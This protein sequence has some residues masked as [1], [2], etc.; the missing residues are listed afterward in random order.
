MHRRAASCFVRA[1]VP[2]ALVVIGGLGMAMPP[3]ANGA[4]GVCGSKAG[5]PSVAYRHVVVIMDENKSFS[6]IIGPRGSAARRRAPFLNHLSKRCGLAANY[7]GITHPSHPNYMAITGGIPAAGSSEGPNVFRQVRRS[8]ETW[9]SY[10]FSMRRPC[11]HAAQYPYKPGHNPGIAWL[12]IAEDCRR[13]D[14]NGR[15]LAADIAHRS[16]PDYAFITPDQCHNM[17]ASCN[18]RR[19]AVRAGDDWLRK[20]VTRLADLP[21]YTAGRTVIFITW[22]EGSHGQGAD[23]LGEHCLAAIN[24][25]D[26]TCHVATLVLSAHTRPGT[27]S[28][29]FFSHYSLLH[30]AERLLG[31]RRYIGHADDRL[32]T[33]MSR[34]FGL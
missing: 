17:H 6:D 12:R 22:D 28:H 30:T 7:R 9:R 32:T 19:G 15:A 29:R 1:S 11:Q 27:R 5:S 16:L 21:S 23:K 31:Y 3:V 34:A 26:E 25:R 10:N 13:W 8:V 18:P 24:R 4:A 14:V 20:W 2:A 33:G